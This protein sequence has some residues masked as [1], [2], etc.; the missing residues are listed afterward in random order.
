MYRL[1]KK[2]N[3]CYQKPELYQTYQEAKNRA[4]GEYMII[5]RENNTDEIIEIGELD[6]KNYDY[7]R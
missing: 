3:N 6:K 7:E 5:K 4:S 1:Y 2:K